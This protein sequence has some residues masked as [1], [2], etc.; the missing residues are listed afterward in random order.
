ML[1]LVLDTAA[2]M[3]IIYLINKGQELNLMPAFLSALIISVGSAIC[4]ALLGASLGVFAVLPMVVVATASI[5]IV[6]GM[7]LGMASIA[8]VI[9][10]VYKI[11]MV[12]G[13]SAMMA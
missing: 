10:V 12:A 8:G 6:S 9:F 7:P 5:W 11:A 4:I 3:L 2:I 13:L 1:G